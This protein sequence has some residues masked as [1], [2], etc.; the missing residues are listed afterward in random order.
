MTHIKFQY[1]NN[2]DERYI[3]IYAYMQN[4]L[5]SPKNSIYRPNTHVHGSKCKQHKKWWKQAPAAN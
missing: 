4:I 1:T 2:S 5:Q 3:M